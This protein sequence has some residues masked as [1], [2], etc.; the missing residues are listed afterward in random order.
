[1]ATDELKDL[2]MLADNLAKIGDMK[3]LS[4][5]ID[6]IAKKVKANNTGRIKANVQ[7]DGSPMPRRKMSIT[8]NEHIAFVYKNP[9][10]GVTLVRNLK[11]YK[12][13]GPCLKGFDRTRGAI[14][15]FRLSRIV[16]FISI[17]KTKVVI[18]KAPQKMFKNIIKAK[19][20]KLKTSPSSATIEFS[21]VAGHVAAI[22]HYGEKD[23]S[24]PKAKEMRYPERKL[25]A[26]TPQD[27]KDIRDIL[28]EELTRDL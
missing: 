18:R 11:N 21:G 25:L 20:F 12:R 28:I 4:E 2:E 15:S 10:T 14:R 26:V 9:V 6:L 17:D 13:L 22:H 5:I 23:R 24:N 8:G 7:P 3:R 19:W 27:E 1:M 16:K